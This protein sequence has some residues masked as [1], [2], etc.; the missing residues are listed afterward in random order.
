MKVTQM[1]YIRVEEKTEYNRE[2]N[3]W[4][5]N[6]VYTGHDIDMTGMAGWIMIPDGP[7]PVTFDLPEGFDYHQF[8]SQA[9]LANLQEQRKELQARFQARLTELDAE[10]NRHLAI[11]APKTENGMDI[12]DSI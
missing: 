7:F 8:Y 11:A 3:T 2:S 4:Q 10:I 9:M 12:L 1:M 5:K 6:T